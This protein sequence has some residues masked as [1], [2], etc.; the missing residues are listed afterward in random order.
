MTSVTGGVSQVFY[1]RR[2][3][4][5]ASHGLRQAD[6]RDTTG[7]DVIVPSRHRRLCGQQVREAV[8]QRGFASTSKFDDT[9]GI[10]VLWAGRT[11]SITVNVM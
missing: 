2:H 4:V 9:A 1:G 3:V 8:A 5:T 10:S 6:C 11:V 7:N